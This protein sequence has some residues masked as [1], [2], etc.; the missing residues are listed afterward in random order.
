M[1]LFNLSINIFTDI[2]ISKVIVIYNK[3]NRCDYSNYRSIYI[4]SQ[5]SKIVEKLKNKNFKFFEQK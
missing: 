3:H 1:Y 4:P 5:F 2:L